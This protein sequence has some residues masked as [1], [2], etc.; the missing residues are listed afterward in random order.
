MSVRSARNNNP[1]NIEANS[2]KWVG[3]SGVEPEGRFAT[4]D[5]PAHGVRAMGRTLET[6]QNKHG[7]T[8][9]NQMISR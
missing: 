3:Q 6:Y 5:T 1:G 9:V 7:L 2:T 8:T 4:F